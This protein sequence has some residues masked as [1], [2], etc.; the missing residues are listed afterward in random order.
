MSAGV[1]GRDPLVMESAAAPS[2]ISRP[3]RTKPQSRPVVL[4]VGVFLSVVLLSPV[5]LASNHPLAWLFWATLLGLTGAIL[6]AEAR[7]PG[8]SELHQHRFLFVLGLI[9][10]AFT[11]FQAAPLPILQGGISVALPAG[12]VV[13]PSLSI[14]PGATFLA[15]IRGA[16]YLIFFWLALRVA[17]DPVR[18]RA[19]GTVLVF[20]IAIHAFFAVLAL[21][22][23]NDANFFAEKQAFFGMATGTFINKNSFATFLGMGIVLGLAMIAGARNDATQK[24]MS[25]LKIMLVLA[26]GISLVA[27]VL[28]QSRMGIAATMIAGTFVLTSG[29]FSFIQRLAL[30]F[31]IAAVI[32]VA[33]RLGLSGQ[34]FDLQTSTTTRLELYPQILRM[35]M[36][37]PL[38]GFGL[39]SFALA[40]EMYH[41]PPVTADFVWDRGHSTYLSLWTESGVLFGTLPV[42]AGGI[43]MVR[44]YRRATQHSS[45]QTMAMAGLGALILGALHSLVDFSLEIQANAFLLI[46]LVAL[47]LGSAKPS[48]KDR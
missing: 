32:V 9:F 21:K 12:D 3:A 6:S 28:T 37:R 34:F 38:T 2:I 47:G 48:Q 16:S 40:F 25:A 29:K 33:A 26:T 45:D 31:G 17:A 5:P 30:T 10:V 27:L 15:G 46:A 42:L 18:A 7:Q 13:F 23:F 4:Y 11:L 39:D 41:A 43:A 20:G 35:I 19:I 22:A 44:L 24:P 36:D 1:F 14:A 8:R